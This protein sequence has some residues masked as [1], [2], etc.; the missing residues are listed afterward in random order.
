MKKRKA[1]AM[2]KRHV[3]QWMLLLGKGWVHYEAVNEMFGV[4]RKRAWVEKGYIDKD[5]GDITLLD[6]R[7]KLSAKALTMLG[8]KENSND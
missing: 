3:V 4:A 7:Y 6:I 5:T 8:I 2:Y 1:Y